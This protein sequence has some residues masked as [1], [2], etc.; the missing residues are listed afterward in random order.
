MVPSVREAGLM[1]NED[2]IGNSYILILHRES[3]TYPMR[4][5]Q[6]KVSITYKPSELQMQ[7][8]VRLGGGMLDA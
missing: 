2:R 6:A 1:E 8:V 4:G 3:I 7:G 5:Y